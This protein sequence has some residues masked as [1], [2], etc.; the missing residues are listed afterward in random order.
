MKCVKVLH[1]PT[2]RA[3][4]R[5]YAKKMKFSLMTNTALFLGA[6][7]LATASPTKKKPHDAMDVEVDVGWC[8]RGSSAYGPV[9]DVCG[10]VKLKHGLCGE[11]Y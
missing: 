5:P 11:S 7:Y 8:R 9:D 1:I 4:L 2:H 3:S 10:E 6:V